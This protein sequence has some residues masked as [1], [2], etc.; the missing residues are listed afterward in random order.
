MVLRLHLPCSSKIE[1][2][3]GSFLSWSLAESSGL[4][5]QSINMNDVRFATKH[6]LFDLVVKGTISVDKS[7]D[8]SVIP[9]LSLCIREYRIGQCKVIIE[10]SLI[11]TKS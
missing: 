3:L 9:R 1:N 11:R 5:D 10:G 6:H 7:Y 4:C 8:A 2:L